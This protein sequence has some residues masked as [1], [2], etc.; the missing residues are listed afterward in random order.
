M[1]TSQE[2]AL[3]FA[4]QYH[5]FRALGE[6]V[7]LLIDAVAAANDPAD[8]KV[9]L[10]SLGVEE[11]PQDPA[12]AGNELR[13]RIRTETDR[14]L[15]GLTRLAA[16]SHHRLDRVT[17]ETTSHTLATKDFGNGGTAV[18]DL[19]HTGKHSHTTAVGFVDRLSPDHPLR[20]KLP[21]VLPKVDGRQ[22]VYLGPPVT[23][24]GGQLVAAGDYSMRHVIERTILAAEKERAEEERLAEENKKR[25][26]LLKERFRTISE[27]EKL[28]VEVDRIQGQ[29]A[30]LPMGKLARL[31]FLGEAAQ[32]AALD[33]L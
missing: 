1:P 20:G 27:T 29:L 6:T 25:D 3:N 17:K 9:I 11:H 30:G 19:G 10:T 8:L 24:L 12:A 21:A 2:L 5:A 13:N 26:E 33:A 14:L 4:K 16:M 15:N 23:S 28:R 31:G 18:T 32:E 7:H 22:V